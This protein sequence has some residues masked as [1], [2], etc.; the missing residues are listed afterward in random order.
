MMTKQ[1]GLSIAFFS[2]F[3]LLLTGCFAVSGLWTG[4]GLVYDRHNVYKKVTDYQLS[5]DSNRALYRD[6]VF[7][8]KDCSID[9][10]AFNGDLLIAGH[11]GSEALREEAYT[12]LS[13]VVG[14]RRFFNQLAIGTPEDG[15]VEDAW[16]TTNIRGQ[17]V[18]DSEIDQH[19]FKV[20][21]SDRIVYI[22]GDVV[23]DQATRVI[24]L[25]RQTQG[26]RRVVKL[27]RIYRLS[28]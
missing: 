28:N 12:R 4:A 13:H 6:D 25:A 2:G 27:L 11:V 5:A 14:V 19:Q 18:A 21:T 22:M 26:V 24:A 23:S 1:R 8:R 10:A 9:V 17:M 3:C 15:T 7:K 20:I 16:I